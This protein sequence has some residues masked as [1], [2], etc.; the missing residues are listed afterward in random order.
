LNHARSIQFNP[1]IPEMNHPTPTPKSLHSVEVAIIQERLRQARYSFNTALISSAAFATIS[2]LG[3]AIVLFGAGK[4]G[5]V[6]ASTGMAGS[7]GCMRLA[8]DANDRLDKIMDEV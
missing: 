2:F 1:L 3:A 5:A 8:K 4:E 6:I 7:V